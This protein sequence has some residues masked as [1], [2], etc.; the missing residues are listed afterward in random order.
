MLRM[1][2]QAMAM[3]AACFILT[4]ATGQAVAQ[5]RQETLLVVVEA[6]MNSLDMH[7][8]GTSSRSSLAAWNLYDRLVSFGIKTLPDGTQMYDYS[9]IVPELAESYTVSPDGKSFTFKIR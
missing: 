9:K 5:S 2:S 1:K 8:L 6:G 3:A 4:A 7:G